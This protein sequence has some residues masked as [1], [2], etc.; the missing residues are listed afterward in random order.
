[1]QVV[2]E[3]RIIYE[4]CTLTIAKTD[5]VITIK[6][7]N[8]ITQLTNSPAESPSSPQHPDATFASVFDSSAWSRRRSP[9][10]ISSKLCRDLR[11]CL[12]RFW[13]RIESGILLLPFVLMVHCCWCLER[14]NAVVD[15]WKF[16]VEWWVHVMCASIDLTAMPPRHSANWRRSELAAKQR[17]SFP[18]KDWWES[19][20]LAKTVTVTDVTNHLSGLQVVAVE[21]CRSFSRCLFAGCRYCNVE[22]KEALCVGREALLRRRRIRHCWCLLLLW[23]A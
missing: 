15:V 14:W 8:N 12:G 11:G 7:A 9:N 18:K 2:Y 6:P 13:N 16:D 1:M 10:G 17:S 3:E 19:V 22:C 20:S 5:K 21:P 4:L 23:R